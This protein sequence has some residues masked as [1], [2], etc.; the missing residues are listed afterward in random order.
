MSTAHVLRGNAGQRSQEVVTDQLH[1]IVVD[2]Q[3][4]TFQA[5]VNQNQRP[6]STEK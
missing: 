5:L 4:K 1:E 2:S 6:N 3:A